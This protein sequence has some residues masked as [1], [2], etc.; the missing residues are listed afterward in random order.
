MD[1]VH[2]MDLFG[3][4]NHRNI[5]IHHHRLLT[6]VENGSVATVIPFWIVPIVG[7][8]AGSGRTGR[9]RG[10]PIGSDASVVRRLSSVDCNVDGDRMGGIVVSDLIGL[11]KP[12]NQAVGGNGA[13][14]GLEACLLG[15][16]QRAPGELK[17]VVSSPGTERQEQAGGAEHK[18]WPGTPK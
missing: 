8:S 18:R 2:P 15:D 6:A 4:L 11:E 9:G 10:S 16:D 14:R 7:R 12:P 17:R 1:V 13:T 5:Q 3:F